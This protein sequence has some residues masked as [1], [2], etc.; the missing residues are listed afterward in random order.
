MERAPTGQ[1]PTHF[2]QP[3]QAAHQEPLDVGLARETYLDA[4]WAAHFARRTGQTRFV[5][6]D[7]NGT[8]RIV[9][10]SGF[11]R[12][13]NQAQALR[14]DLMRTGIDSRLANL[15]AAKHR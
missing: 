5:L 2:S 12:P 15:R 4:L 8:A 1:G 3:V 10:I 13:A 14:T 11:H 6:R 7:P 9:D